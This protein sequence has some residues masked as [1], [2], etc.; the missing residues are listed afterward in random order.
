MTG[1]ISDIFSLISIRQYVITKHQTLSDTPDYC[2]VYLRT[3]ATHAYTIMA[4][5]VLYF[6]LTLFGPSQVYS[7]RSIIGVSGGEGCTVIETSG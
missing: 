5:I 7:V 3:P 2:H 4:K 6:G 1:K